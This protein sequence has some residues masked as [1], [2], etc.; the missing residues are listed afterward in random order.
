MLFSRLK[1]FHFPASYQ[2]ALGLTGIWEVTTNKRQSWSSR[3]KTAGKAVKWLWTPQMDGMFSSCVNSKSFGTT[4][5]P[6]PSLTSF[7]MQAAIQKFASLEPELYVIELRQTTPADRATA[8]LVPTAACLRS[9]P[10]Y[11]LCFSYLWQRVALRPARSRPT[12][13]N[14]LPE[15]CKRN[16]CSC[17]SKW[18]DQE[19]WSGTSGTLTVQWWSC[20]PVCTSTFR[21][22]FDWQA[23]DGIMS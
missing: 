3:L 9:S 16:P 1:V 14:S 20:A 5:E 7:Y 4:R 18:R 23:T 12:R 6:L 22:S 13:A 2:F 8:P 17:F 19:Q 15:L 11:F 10:H 21:R